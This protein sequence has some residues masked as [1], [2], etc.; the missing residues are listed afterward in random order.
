MEMD[1]RVVKAAVREVLEEDAG[2]GQYELARRWE[3][4]TLVLKPNDS[5]LQSKEIPI[6]V[7]FKKITA[8]RERL[9]VLEQR[10]NN[11]SNLSLEEK[12]EFQQLISRAYGSLTT[13]NIL[14][15]DDDDKFVGMKGE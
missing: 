14:F 13:F 7:L 4:G 6:E 9:R 5:G 10:L 3:D 2:F 11:H 15:R 8:V 12:A 1:W